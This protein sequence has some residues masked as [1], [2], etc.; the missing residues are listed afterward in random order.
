MPNNF[1]LIYQIKAN[2]ANSCQANRAPCAGCFS[3]PPPVFQ[4]NQNYKPQLIGL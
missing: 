3:H 1:Q 4:R 2:S